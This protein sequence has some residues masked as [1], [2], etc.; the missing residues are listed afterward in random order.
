MHDTARCLRYPSDSTQAAWERAQEATCG[1]PPARESAGL[2]RR[3]RAGP[4]PLRLLHPR[5]RL[6]GPDP[7]PRGSTL[8]TA[9]LLLA[10]AAQA[11]TYLA[12]VA[13]LLARVAQLLARAALSLARVDQP[14]ARAAQLFAR[15]AQPLAR[16]AR[17]SLS[18]G[19]SRAVPTSHWPWVSSRAACRHAGSP[20]RIAIAVYVGAQ[21]GGLGLARPEVD[22]RQHRVPY[23]SGAWWSRPILV[24]E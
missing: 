3:G 15:V 13:H 16:V 19:R 12:R 4:Q 9:A 24:R 22:S 20:A 10:R 8:H 2:V 1:L 23:G 11:I 14:L 21:W 17:S 6:R 7:R 18:P 5:P